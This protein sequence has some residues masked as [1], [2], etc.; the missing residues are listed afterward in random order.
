MHHGKGVGAAAA[1]LM[2]HSDRLALAFASGALALPV[3]GSVLVLRA[4]PSAFLDMLPRDRLRCV[5]GFRPAHDSLAEAGYPVAA[6][7]EGPATAPAMVVV[8]LTRSRAENLGNVAFGLAA[9]AP[10]GTLVATGAKGD[11]VDSLA[12]QVARALPLDGAF[13]KAHG[14]VFWLT[15]PA[16]LPAAAAAWARDAELRPNAEG[17]LTAPGMFSPDHADPGSRR[18]AAV[19]AARHPGRLSG[20]V[21]DLGAGWGWLAQAVLAAAPAITELDLHEA[22]ALALDAARANVTDPRARF[23]WT[24]VTRLGAGGAALRRGHRQ[25]ALPPGPRRRSRPRRRLRLRCRAHPQALGAALPRRQPPAPLRGRPCHRL[26][27]VGEALR[28]RHLQGH[29]RRPA[30]PRLVSS[31]PEAVVCSRSTAIEENATIG[32]IAGPPGGCARRG[33]RSA[34]QGAHRCRKPVTS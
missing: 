13:V 32:H 3:A 2:S 6:R 33:F 34:R 18:L 9:L 10:G 22:E 8:N 21:A 14:R 31:R 26:P 30:P 11:G 28:G 20:R 7:A 1:P 29:P 17:F 24:D 19:V 23:H 25:P 5:Q 15:R 4:A 16:T 27:R 12:R